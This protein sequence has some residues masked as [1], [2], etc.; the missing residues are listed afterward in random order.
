MS[1]R[2]LVVV[3]GGTGGHVFPGVAVAEAWRAAGGRVVYLGSERG[4]EARVV[5]PLGIP[6]E[7]V[8]ARRLKNAGVVERL[9]TL[10]RLPGAVWAGRAL[11]KR[12]DP[13]VVL[14][15][16]GYVSGPVML[17]AALGR[18]PCAVAEQNA[19]PGLTNRILSR[20]VPRVYSAFPEIADRL[21]RRKVRLL[22]NPVREAIRAAAVHAPAAGRGRH[23]LILG[24]SQ[25]A[26]ALNRLLPGVV[27]RLRVTVPELVVVHQTGRDKDAEV[28][29]LYGDLPGV[30][31][32]PFIEDMAAALVLADLVVARSGATTVA[33][34]ACIG[35]P[36][37]FVPFPQ[38]ADDHQAA[39]A[40][41]L[42]AAGAA[43]MEREESLDEATLTS[44]LE[45]L[46]GDPA[47][48]A[49]MGQRARALGRPDAAA[50]IAADLMALAGGAA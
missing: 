21:P 33:E 23:L 5:P 4:M 44:R 9:R 36:A 37:L 18:R 26:R 10:L 39:N 27:K 45:A 16:G 24:G 17:A 38:A 40:A 1:G 6:F 19:K 7:A 3:G 46:L 20:F 35:R 25:G 2:L 14:G 32:V 49:A 11:L 29:E 30:S 43:A 50:D 13:A 34:L 47:Q 8:P 12:L 22:G 48:L 31:V 42:V 41:A 15:V 28:R